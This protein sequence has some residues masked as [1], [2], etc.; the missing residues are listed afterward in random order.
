MRVKV[1][2]ATDAL[3]PISSSSSAHSNGENA[4]VAVS[5]ARNGAQT[6]ERPIVDN[7]AREVVPAPSALSGTS[8]TLCALCDDLMAAAFKDGN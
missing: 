8:G 1:A 4:P 2:R 3:A 5:S 7:C 6:R